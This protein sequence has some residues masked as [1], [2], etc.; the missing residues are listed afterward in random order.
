[1][2][3]IRSRELNLQSFVLMNWFP[4]QNCR[5]QLIIATS[6]QCGR[7]ISKFLAHDNDFPAF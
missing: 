4:I 3:M 1:M 5:V 7:E 6:L 2:I